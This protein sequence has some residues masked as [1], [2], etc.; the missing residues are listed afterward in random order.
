M[1]LTKKEIF[2]L[3]I[4]GIFLINAIVTIVTSIIQLIILSNL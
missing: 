2:W 1:K 3:T 4:A